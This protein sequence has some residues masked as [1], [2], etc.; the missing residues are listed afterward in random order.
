MIKTIQSLMLLIIFFTLAYAGYSYFSKY[1]VTTKN[2]DLR[3]TKEGVDVHIKKFIVEHEKSGHKDWE[4]KADFAQINKKKETTKMQNIEYIYINENQ[5]KFKV[6]ADSGTLTNKTNDLNLEGNVRM[7]IERSIVKENLG[8]NSTK[9][10]T[11][12]K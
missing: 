9:K 10:V 4:L 2:I 1:K 7:L 12:K 11:I 6:Y 8:E 5:K 3:L